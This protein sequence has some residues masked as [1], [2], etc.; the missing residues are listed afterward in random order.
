MFDTEIHVFILHLASF[1]LVW[2]IHFY[3]GFSRLSEKAP[4]NCYVHAW[5]FAAY[6][7]HKAPGFLQPG[8][9]PPHWKQRTGQLVRFQSYAICTS[10]C[11][12][13][14]AYIE[15]H[16]CSI[17]TWQKVRHEQYA[18][19]SE[20]HLWVSAKIGKLVCTIQ[21]YWKLPC[22]NYSI[23]KDEKNWAFFFIC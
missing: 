5:L 2:K 22:L 7:W 23:A 16:I 11:N 3:G 15:K 4:N 8:L 10:T 9:F 13:V 17:C 12:G 14:S 18:I 6:H 19:C 1:G 20:L 21:W